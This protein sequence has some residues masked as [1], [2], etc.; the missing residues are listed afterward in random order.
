MARSGRC[1]CGAVTLKLEGEPVAVRQCWCRQCQQIA[2]G[3]ATHNAMFPTENVQ[4]TGELA[5]S[6][7]TAASGN[8]LTFHFC[9]R[10]GTQAYAQSSARPQFRTV[11][12]GFIDEPHGL[13]PEMAI[14]T[15]EAPAWAQIDPA[16]PQFAQ[17]PPPP[18]PAPSG[19]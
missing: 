11:R 12:L 19:S 6:S 4:F 15:A 8:T 9:P 14:W 18:N 16:I 7:W 3:G 1:A 13:K 10:C 17:M 5:A 2:A